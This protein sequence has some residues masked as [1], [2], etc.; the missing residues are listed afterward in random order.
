MNRDFLMRHIPVWLEHERDDNC[1]LAYMTKDTVAARR[2]PH[3][4]PS[5]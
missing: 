5:Q 4:P 3:Q 1:N 2:I